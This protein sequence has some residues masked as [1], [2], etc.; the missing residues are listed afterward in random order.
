MIRMAAN[1]P[2]AKR[3]RSNIKEFYQ[4]KKVITMP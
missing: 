2:T 3:K 4:I 1:S